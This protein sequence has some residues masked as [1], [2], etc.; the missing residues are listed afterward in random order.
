MQDENEE[1]EIEFLGRAMPREQIKTPIESVKSYQ[2]VKGKFAD[3]TEYVIGG[4]PARL[5]W[6][7][8]Q[9]DLDEV[10]VEG[11]EEEED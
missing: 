2:A 9:G 4:D 7:M 6:W 10:E 3:G 1:G 8:R 11:D 5:A